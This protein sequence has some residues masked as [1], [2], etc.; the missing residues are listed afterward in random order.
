LKS[1]PADALQG[2]LTRLFLG[3]RLQALLASETRGRNL[4]F[5]PNPSHAPRANSKKTNSLV[6]WRILSAFGRSLALPLVD[7]CA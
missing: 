6:S 1:F 5:A 2:D 4:R 3:L 7:A